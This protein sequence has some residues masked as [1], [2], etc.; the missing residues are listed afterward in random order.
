[1]PIIIEQKAEINIVAVS[2]PLK[3][4]PDWLR[5]E[6]LTTMIYI[7]ARNVVVPAIISV[8]ELVLFSPKEKYSASILCSIITGSL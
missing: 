6:G 2:T 7:E 4:I 8:L 3:G 1:M 5:I